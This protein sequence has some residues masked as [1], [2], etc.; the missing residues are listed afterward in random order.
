MNLPRL[1]IKS[2]FRNRFRAILTIAGTAVA[3]LAFLFLRTVVDMW[4]AGV[5]DA[6]TD[7]YATRHRVSITMP[8]PLSYFHKVKSIPGVT[9]ASYANWL[10]HMYPKDEKAFFANF[11]IDGDTWFDVYPELVVPP[12]QFAAWKANPAGAIVG[13]TLAAKYGW[14]IGDKVTLTGTIFAGDWTFTIAA[15]Y[16]STSKVWDQS[17]FITHWKYLNDGVPETQKNQIGWLIQKVQNPEK[18]AEVARA[19]DAM[20]AN[21]DAETLSESERAFNLSFLSMYSAI[22]TALNVV[23]IVILLIMAMIVG[24]TIAMAVRE[25]T[26]EYGILRAIGFKSGFLA[27]VVVGETMVLSLLGGALGIALAFPLVNGFGS[28][29][30]DNFGSWFPYFNLAPS[31]AMLAFGLTIIVGLAS[32]LLPASGVFRLNVINALRRID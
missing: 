18:G 22:F 9:A 24:N 19:I 7:R 30:E 16:H 28:F 3:V 29:V 2:A 15:M 31:S 27:Q 23:S 10:G 4:N 12:D 20:F 14:K 8:L 5:E 17:S 1:I 11:A 32:G 13:K 6:A 21:S 26:H 25:R